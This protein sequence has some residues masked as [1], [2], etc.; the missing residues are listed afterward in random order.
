MKR[1]ISYESPMGGGITPLR[2]QVTSDKTK[3]ALE[4]S[5]LVLYHRQVFLI[6]TMIGNLLHN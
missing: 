1:I 6:I 5:G 2:V 3:D 4:D